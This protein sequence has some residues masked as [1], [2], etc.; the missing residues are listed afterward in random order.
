MDAA[1]ADAADADAAAPPSLLTRMEVDVSS[2]VLILLT[3]FV[4]FIGAYYAGHVFKRLSLPAITAYFLVGLLLGPHSF[5]MVNRDS[6]EWLKLMDG[7]CLCMIGLCAGTEVSFQ[8]LAP[9]LSIVWVYTLA[10]TAGTWLLVTPVVHFFVAPNVPF[11]VDMAKQANGPSRVWAITSLIGTLMVARSPASALAVLRDTDGRGPFCTTTLAVVVVKDVVTVLMYSLNL[12]YVHFVFGENATVTLYTLLAPFVHV[13]WSGIL[14]LLGGLALATGPMA[15]SVPAPAL[16]TTPSI[17]RA[18]GI[19]LMTYARGRHN[20][21]RLSSGAAR[22]AMI[23]AVAGI[24]YFVAKNTGGEPLLTCLVAGMVIANPLPTPVRTCVSSM[25]RVLRMQR[26][27]TGLMTSNIMAH[28]GESDNEAEARRAETHRHF[29][30][31]MPVVNVV[32]FSLAGTYIRPRDLLGSTAHASIIFATRMFA[33]VGSTAVAAI[34]LTRGFPES[35][36][37]G[38][39]YLVAT[40]GYAWMAYVTQAGVAM[41]LIKLAVNAFPSWGGEFAALSTAV[42]VANQVIGPLL[43]KHAIVRS[44]ES[45]AGLLHVDKSATPASGSSSGDES[46]APD[47]VTVTA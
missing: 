18:S 22:P 14:G 10:I 23:A 29:A 9:H 34:V 25:R 15:P 42:V 16:P 20:V 6:L 17:K 45:H 32:F 43:F 30:L 2:C 4:L 35:T 26:E 36:N 37:A 21:I 31:L 41:G 19:L 27:S 47:G 3:A 44:G 46:A 7:T 8:E 1:A 40:S 13:M 39:G 24:L 5:N 33:L 38:G 12:E 11:L 28:H